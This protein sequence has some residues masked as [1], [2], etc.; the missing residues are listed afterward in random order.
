MPSLDPTY[1]SRI[2]LDTTEAST[3]AALGAFRG[4]QELFQRQ[5]PEILMA[6]KQG[7]LV[8]SAESSNRIEGVTA[9]PDR[10][11][12]IVHKGS[13]PATRSEQEIA[14]YRDALEL[15]HG[16]A[17]EM[18]FTVNI[19]K[20]LHSLLYRY[21]SGQGGRWKATNNEIVERDADGNVVRVRFRPP[22]PIRTPQMMDDLVTGYAH[23]VD[24][25]QEPLIIV[26]LAILD[27]LAIHPFSDGNGRTGRLLSLMLLYRSG[28]EV[29]RYISLERI[30]EES[31][32]TYYEALERSSQGWHD[33]AHNPNPWLGYFWGMLIR[34]YREFEERVGSIRTG[35]GAK[36]DLVEA[37]IARQTGPF[38]ISEIEAQSPGVTRDWV[39]LVLR[40]LRDEGKIRVTGRGR[41]AKWI[42]LDDTGDDT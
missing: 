38:S 36:G 28:F 15:I 27:F 34:A 7:A 4:R 26:P 17:S 35:R 42:K 3:V 10:V 33:D 21:Q 8:E 30:I 20:Q 18:Q 13:I 1:L 25:E 9:S 37:A 6:L 14:G 16:S 41:G 31:R 23:A 39:R 40:R 19:V 2:R 32:E 12:A 29:G 24:A 5:T 22:E 11:E